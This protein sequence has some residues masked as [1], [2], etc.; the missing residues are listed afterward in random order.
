PLREA[1]GDPAD[2][3]LE[4]VVD[5]KRKLRGA[6]EHLDRAVVV[7]RSESARD[8]AEIRLEPLAQGG[9]QLVGPVAHDRDAC[10]LEPELE[11]LPSEEGPVQVSAVA[12]NELAR[13]DDEDRA[14]PGQAAVGARLIP[15]GETSTIDGS[16]PGKAR[17]LPSGFAVR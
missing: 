15:F 16:P 6:R 3:T 5:P 12:A 11:Y 17:S 14:R 10:R 4:L 1:A 2:L 9:L 7:R 8:D 13:G